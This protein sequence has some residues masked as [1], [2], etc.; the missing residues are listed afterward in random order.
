MITPLFL[1]MATGEQIQT[2]EDELFLGGK[3]KLPPASRIPNCRLCDSAQTFMFQVAFPGHHDWDGL[4]LAV[5]ACIS[6]ATENFLIPDMLPGH[7]RGADTGELFRLVPAELFF[8]R[9]CDRLQ[10]DKERL[11]CQNRVPPPEHGNEQFRK[12]RQSWRK[13]GLASWRRISKVVRRSYTDGFPPS[14]V[15]GP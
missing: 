1:K 3:P 2:P 8:Q 5:F 11:F 4:S 7:L 14:A 12:H 13:S 6:C 9:F 10:H 15:A